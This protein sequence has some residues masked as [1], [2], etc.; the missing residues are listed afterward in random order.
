MQRSRVWNQRAM[1]IVGIAAFAGFGRPADGL[2]ALLGPGTPYEE[3]IRRTAQMVSDADAQRLVQRT[4]L[5]LLNLTWEDTGRYKNSAVGPN[6]SDMTIQVASTERNGRREVRLMPVIRHPNFSDKTADIGAGDFT[7]LVGNQMGRPLRRVSLEEFLKNP[8]RYM[9]DPGSWRSRERTLWSDR[10]RH[11]LVSAQACFLPVPARGKA[12]FNPVLFNYQSTK[13]NP[14]VLTILATREGTSMTVVDNHRDAFSSEWGWGQRLFHNQNGMRASLTG[15]R[16]SDFIG[17]GGR[18]EGP[19]GVQ[20][21]DSALNMVL[22]IQVPLKYKEVRRDYLESMAPSAAPGGAVAKRSRGIENAVIGH[23]DLEGPFTE[24]GGLSV[25]RDPRFPVRVTVQ[26]YKATEDGQI[27][28][29]DV[30]EIKRDLDRVYEDADYVG[31][32][33][34]EGRTGRPT[35][36]DGSKVQP[37]GWWRDFWTRYE[38]DTGVR[39]EVAVERLRRLMGADFLRQP[40]CELYLRDSL[41]A[42]PPTKSTDGLGKAGRRGF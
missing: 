12:T 32:L 42:L 1:A 21:A 34:T 15:E 23:G 4:G 2:V 18:N 19:G 37:A 27:R 40:V 7:L 38:A 17:R 39:R 8:D 22:L 14:A 6:I 25:E 35:E 5:N 30:R 9:S 16:M 20:V 33:V 31:S 26:F 28:A 24:V 36:Y 13:D 3:A 41:R 11:V 29:D 10:D